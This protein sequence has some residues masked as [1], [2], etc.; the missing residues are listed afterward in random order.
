[1]NADGSGVTRLTSDP[2]D[3]SGP[4]WSPDG[5]KIAFDS[6]RNGKSEIYVMNPDG[7]GVI[8]LTTNAAE[9]FSPAWTP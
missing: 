2:H 4:T 3:D 7:T 6:E 8:R 1:M 9:D 5:S